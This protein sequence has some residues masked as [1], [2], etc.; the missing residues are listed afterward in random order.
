MYREFEPSFLAKLRQETFPT[1]REEHFILIRPPDVKARGEISGTYPAPFP[2]ESWNPL[3]MHVQTNNL[4][5]VTVPQFRNVHT[6]GII[7]NENVGGKRNYPPVLGNQ[8]NGQV[9][10]THGNP[11]KVPYSKKSIKP[12]SVKSTEIC[13]FCLQNNERPECYSTHQL[14]DEDGRVT[15][16]VLRKYVCDICGATGDTAHTLSYCPYNKNNKKMPLTLVLKQ[17][18]IDSVGRLK[19]YADKFA[20][21]MNVL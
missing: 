9:K 21:D 1:S 6:S 11:V 17:T 19:S 12:K 18:D 10:Q 13:R 15:C 2:V 8:H 3:P 20:N 4:K 14:K 5:H 7:K 16:H